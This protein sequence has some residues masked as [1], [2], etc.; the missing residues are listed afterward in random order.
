MRKSVF[1]WGIVL[2]VLGVILEF[3]SGAVLPGNI[4]VAL[5]YGSNQILWLFLA[6]IGLIIAVV[7]LILKKKLI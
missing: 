6:A 7:G 4:T 2:L 3:L 5:I 1:I